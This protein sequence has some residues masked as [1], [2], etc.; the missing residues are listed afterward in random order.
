MKQQS[1]L[2]T[3]TEKSDFHHLFVSADEIYKYMES[4]FDLIGRRAYEKF[5][6]RGNAHGHDWEDWYQAESEVLQP[7]PFELED[8]GDAII[9]IFDVAGYCCE[10]LRISVEPQRLRICGMP[11]A[12]EKLSGKPELEL[13]H[14]KPFFFSFSLPID[15]DLSAVAAQIRGDIFEVRLPKRFPHAET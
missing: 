1:V 6:N 7:A 13:R 15:V 14:S 12:E 11:T 9:A 3:Q 10:D 5:E 4:T 8:A 2:T